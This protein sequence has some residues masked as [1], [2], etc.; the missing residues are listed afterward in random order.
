[1]ID[2]A[3]GEVL[4]RADYILSDEVL[5]S[6]GIT[7]PFIQMCVARL[8]EQNG[9]A[10]EHL[11]HECEGGDV[12]LSSLGLQLP[13]GVEPWERKQLSLKS[14]KQLAFLN[15]VERSLCRIEAGLQENVFSVGGD[16]ISIGGRFGESEV[17]EGVRRLRAQVNL[18]AEFHIGSVDSYV[19]RGTN[20]AEMRQ[21]FS[22]LPEQRSRLTSP[23]SGAPGAQS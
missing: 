13:N 1:M 5:S 18:L 15:A 4:K 9:S 14:L 8:V 10:S 21:F 12:D 7:E 23:E 3:V 2:R 19:H 16:L 20:Q 6:I 17:L 11:K 22:R